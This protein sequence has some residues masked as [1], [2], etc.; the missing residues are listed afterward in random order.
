VLLDLAKQYADIVQGIE[1]EKFRIV[2]D[3]YELRAT[4]LLKDGSRL[5]VKDYLFLDG[6][7]KY[8]YHWQDRPG[9]LINRWDNVPHWNELQSYPHH[10]HVGAA[11]VVESSDV[12]T[13][14][15]ALKYIANSSRPGSRRLSQSAP[16]G[17]EE[18]PTER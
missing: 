4:F 3:S 16:V 7:R 2:G 1:V 5:F 8:A 18:D 14:E 15:D 12:R 13:I 11:D 9:R 6:T 10:R 17:T